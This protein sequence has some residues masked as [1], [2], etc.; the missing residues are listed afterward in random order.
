M[1]PVNGPVPS[2]Q[3]ETITRK[4]VAVESGGDCF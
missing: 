2:S 3:R 1:A 4:G